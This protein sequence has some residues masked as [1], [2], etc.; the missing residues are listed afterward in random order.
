MAAGPRLIDGFSVAASWKAGNN[1]SIAQISPVVYVIISIQYEC[2]IFWGMFLFIWDF[3]GA[4]QSAQWI[5]SFLAIIFQPCVHHMDVS[6]N[7]VCRMPQFL[8]FRGDVGDWQSTIN[9]SN[10]GIA[11][12]SDK[13]IWSSGDESGDETGTRPAM[14]NWRNR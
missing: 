11:Y 8:A 2:T 7:R 6:E 14:R 9:E 13:P 4:K 12:F 3:R 1:N 5:P 10:F